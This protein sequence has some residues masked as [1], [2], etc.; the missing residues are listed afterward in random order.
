MGCLRTFAVIALALAPLPAMAQTVVTETVEIIEDDGGSDRTIVEDFAPVPQGIAR[1]GPFRVLDARRAALVDA[2]GS[3]A[4]AQFAAMLHAYPGIA[5]LEM[6]ECPGTYDDVANL[7]LGRMLH[8][9]GLATHVPAGGSVRSGAVELYLAGA[10]RRADRS[11]EFAVHSWEDDNGRQASD[12]AA[13]APVNRAYLAYYREMGMSA[14]AAARFYAMT[15]S[16]PNAQAR[17]LTAAEMDDWAGKAPPV[18]LA[19]LDS[20]SL[21]K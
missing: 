7:R 17:W 16:V 4:P 15:N 18:T 3:D 14:E 11:A 1:Y 10:V 13:D 6:I 12:F 21:L 5:T 20:P 2:T 8:A 9:R 19:S